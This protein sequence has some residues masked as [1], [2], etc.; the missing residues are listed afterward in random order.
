MIEAGRTASVTPS[1]RSDAI[2]SSGPGE[3]RHHRDDE[4]GEAPLPDGVA[5]RDPEP[6]QRAFDVG[7]LPLDP[8]EDGADDPLGEPAE[9]AGQPFGADDEDE[10]DAEPDEQRRRRR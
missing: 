1:T 10:P 3:L 9:L 7:R 5:E 8:A 6:D 2:I 4:R